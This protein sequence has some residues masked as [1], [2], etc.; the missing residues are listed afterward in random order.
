L[1]PKDG[2]YY[3]SIA[4]SASSDAKAPLIIFGGNAYGET[5]AAS[6]TDKF[7]AP[8]YKNPKSFHP[9]LEVYASS[10]RSYTPN[11]G[12]GSPTESTV[13][14]DAE[15]LLDVTL[16]T[17]S[18]ARSG[19]KVLIVGFSIG[20]AVALELAARRPEAVAGVLLA[21]PWSS[22]L[23]MELTIM[24]PYSYAFALW[25][26]TSDVWDSLGHASSLPPEIPVAILSPQ[27]DTVIHPEMHR[28]V[29]DEL[30]TPTKWLLETPL[31]GHEDLAIQAARHEVEIT[32]W[33]KASCARLAS[34][35]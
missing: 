23:N 7:F 21:S 32:K 24:S 11:N 6:L 15:A 31:A 17:A 2:P 25:L 12:T 5:A 4:S 34:G 29:Y 26:W 14:G 30:Q 1:A 20:S 8:Q 10:Y 27:S 33:L 16:D 18:G 28:D 9:H 3:G 13:V 19:R 22:L 35:C